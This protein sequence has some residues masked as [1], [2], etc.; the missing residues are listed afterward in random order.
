[1]NILEKAANI[2]YN[3]G[4][5]RDRQYGPFDWSIEQTQRIASLLVNSEVSIDTVY[6]VLIALKLS[7]QSFSQKEDNMLDAIV[8]MAQWND[9]KKRLNKACECD[10][11]EP[12]L[13]DQKN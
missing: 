5:E 11:C 8:Y 9:H 12:E 10:V 3:R 6:A 7:R 4:E 1:M 2:L 13:N